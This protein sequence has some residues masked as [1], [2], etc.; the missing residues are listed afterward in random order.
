[1]FFFFEKKNEPLG[2][3][4]EYMSDMDSSILN[5]PILP[6]ELIV[7]SPQFSIKSNLRFSRKSYVVS[8]LL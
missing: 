5:H 7:I 6:F 8:L 3:E 4:F 1:M 2:F